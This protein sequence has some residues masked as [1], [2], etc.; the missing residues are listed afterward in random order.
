MWFTLKFVYTDL[1]VKEGPGR[2][3]ANSNASNIYKHCEQ[4]YC[5]LLK[6]HKKYKILTRFEFKIFMSLHFFRRRKNAFTG[7]TFFFKF[8]FLC[9]PISLG[10]ITGKVEVKFWLHGF[11]TF[12]TRFLTGGGAWEIFVCRLSNMLSVKKQSAVTGGEQLEERTRDERTRHK[13]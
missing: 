2:T 11:P 12:L 1:I 6:W 9:C 5:T 3:R 13:K 8:H 4:C 7:L 10:W